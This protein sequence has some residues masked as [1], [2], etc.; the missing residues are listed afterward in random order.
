MDRSCKVLE[1]VGISSMLNTSF[2]VLFIFHSVGIVSLIAFI[3]MS[4][5]SKE[6]IMCPARD[7][8]IAFSTYRIRGFCCWVDSCLERVFHCAGA[9][10]AWEDCSG[11]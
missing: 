8:G 7:A 5:S 4:L 3:W 2:M 11:C 10:T 1:A 9:G 6:D